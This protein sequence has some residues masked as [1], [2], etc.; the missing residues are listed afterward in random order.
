MVIRLDDFFM[1]QK[2]SLFFSGVVVKNTGNRWGGGGDGVWEKVSVLFQGL[3]IYIAVYV[4][5]SFLSYSSTF[6]FLVNS[7]TLPSGHS[8]TDPT[9][10]P[11]PRRAHRPRWRMLPF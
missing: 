7:K 3:S 6:S 9:A 1:K 8:A 10:N 5:F 4:F 2:F 11:S